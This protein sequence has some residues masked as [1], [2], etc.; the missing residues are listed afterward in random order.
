MGVTW[1]GG[2]VAW[3]AFSRKWNANLNANRNRLQVLVGPAGMLQYWLFYTPGSV[4]VELLSHQK[5]P[6]EISF[7][8][9]RRCR[10]FVAP[11]PSPLML[12]AL[13]EASVAVVA[14]T[15][16]QWSRS[17]GYLNAG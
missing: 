8:L 14:L 6:V 2:V 16:W 15:Q 4:T 10:S 1:C 17:L 9:Y 7:C 5:I 11:P 3:C 13:N 12:G